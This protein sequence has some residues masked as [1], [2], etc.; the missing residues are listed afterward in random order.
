MRAN[1]PLAPRPDERTPRLVPP[2]PLLVA[3]LLVLALGLL[4]SWWIS[5]AVVAIATCAT[6]VVVW[7]A[8]SRG[9]NP[10]VIAVSLLLFWMPFA[11]TISRFNIGPQELGVYGVCLA[12]ALFEPRGAR[13]WIVDLLTSVSVPFRLLIGLF[14]LACLQAAVR[15]A[16]AGILPTTQ[17]LRSVVIYPLLFALLVAYTIRT[18]RA[19]RILFTAFVA[20]AV[21]FAGYALSLWALG[22]D[23]GNG[24]VAGRLGS[25][26]TFLAQY[27]P[28]NLALYLVLALAF[29]PGILD[30]V[31]SAGGKHALPVV[32][33]LVS[34][35]LMSAS[36]VLTGSR[37]ALV[38]LLLGVL[39]VL[40]FFVF[41][42]TA[43]QRLVAAGIILAGVSGVAVLVLW[44]GPSLLGRYAGL[45][46]PASLSTDANVTFRT[47]LYTRAVQVI[48]AHPLDGI[49]L[50]GFSSTGV[51]PF[52]PHDTY[53]DL[54]VSAGVFAMLAFVGALVLGLWVA[55]R[56]AGA[57]ARSHDR[58]GTLY[59][60][61]F[62]FG[63]AAFTVQGFVE[64]YDAQPRIAPAIWIL[65]LS[66]TVATFSSSARSER[67]SEWENKSDGMPVPYGNYGEDDEKSPGWKELKGRVDLH[68]RKPA[69]QPV[70]A[71]AGAQRATGSPTLDWQWNLY[72]GPLPVVE[73]DPFEV[74]AKF[75]AASLRAAVQASADASAAARR[76]TPRRSLVAQLVQRG[77]PKA[78]TEQA[79][80]AT[81]QMRTVQAAETLLKR[82]PSSYLWNQLYMLW[83]FGANFILSVI[84]TRGLNSE[85]YGIFAILTSIVSTLL[86]MFALGLED[87][88]GVVIPRALARGGRG[89]A[90]RLI[91]RLLGVRLVV[92][93]CIGILLALGLAYV[94]PLMERV[95]VVPR[96]FDRS[97]A[98]YLGLRPVLMAAYLVGSAV[99][100]LQA[101][102]FSSALRS[103]MTLLIGGVSQA[104]AI[105]LTIVALYAGY[106][107]DGIFFVQAAVSWVSVLAYLVALWPY[108]R[109]RTNT[110]VKDAQDVRKIMF[111]AWLT[112]VTNGA[113][114][115]QLDIMLMSAF[116]IGYAQIG[117]YNLAY[118]L[119]SI[120]SV[121]LI[122]GLGGVGMAAMSATFTAG[123]PRRLAS[124]WRATVML[125]LVLAVPLQIMTFVLAGQVVDV[126]YGPHYLGAAPLLQ[127][128]LVASIVGRVIGGGSNQSSLYVVGR[129]RSVLAT[130]WAG[131]VINV[132]LDV[133]FIQ[134]WGPAG[135]IA[136]TGFSQVWVGIIEYLM[137][138]GQIP[139][140]FP[141]GFALRVLG[142]STLA[143]LAVAWW[144]PVGL[145]GLCARGAIF[146][147]LFVLGVLIFKLGNSDELAELTALN[148]RLQRLID[149]SNR[150]FVVRARARGQTA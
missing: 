60:L 3:G 99:M 18:R 114:G 81:G 115:K 94:V 89:A 10:L 21:V 35:A 112:N 93:G 77:K 122:S 142:I 79:E 85:Q 26:L 102:F 132:I 1:N 117:Y 140:R 61:G 149:L 134:M 90:G 72:T 12:C 32:A 147:V 92:M 45:L 53:L 65:V 146:A 33:L 68:E 120:V 66:A 4:A 16:H 13:R 52:S 20:G 121:L 108:L 87:A 131:V 29:V 49:G 101:A 40:A 116:A 63:L 24:A 123:G 145:L 59:A 50:A 57:C 6:I 126:L 150:V 38:G 97:V 37:G 25:E 148:P 139:T 28:N 51:V 46:N 83:V 43:R 56:R 15:V 2:V 106:G 64:A 47:Q 144:T 19:E 78:D 5:I 136:A 96:D 113:L 8:R 9:M 91:W 86:F 143:G 31:I 95:G 70:P 67:L 118:Q 55:L 125:Q 41:S 22:I 62:A 141:L 42:G 73:D 36:V 71:G 127:L 119:V 11:T 44:K 109:V 23:V 17:A 100:A 137:L 7:W 104:L 105:V 128:Y 111:P 124:M 103:R 54:W 76:G 30:D 129:Q 69:A 74:S 80:T 133:V 39:V 110:A 48:S 82:A 135:A 75:E 130:R 14:A 58:A 88:A 138:R 107:I 34:A 27:H 84:I 98:G